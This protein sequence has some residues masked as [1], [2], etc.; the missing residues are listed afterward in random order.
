[1]KTA[2][3]IVQANWVVPIEPL[4]K[5][6]ERHALVIVDGRIAAIMPQDT[7]GQHYRSPVLRDLSDHVLLPGLVNAHTHAAMNLLRGY[8]NDTPLTI[9]LEDHIW[10]A[11]AK[12]VSEEFVRDGTEL[13]IAEMMLGGTTCFQDMYMFPYAAGQ[14]AHDTGMRAV[15]GLILIDFPT[16]WAV[17]ASDCLK[18]A[19]TVHDQLKPYLLLR[20]AF[21]PH[22]LYT[23]PDAS[24]QQMRILAEELEL[25][26]HIHLH[27]TAN[28]VK[29]SVAQ[30]RMRPIERLQQL[31]IFGPNLCAV[32][33][34]Q[35]LPAEIT[36]LSNHNVNV[37]HC[38]ESNMKLASGM[39]PVKSLLDA[40][41]NV[42][43]GTD[44]AASNNDLDMFGEMRT[45]A[46]LAKVVAAD[47]SAF[48]AAE[49]LYAATLGGARALGLEAEIGS[50]AIGKSA[51]FI[52]VN[53]AS[54]QT[55]PVF[56]PIPQLVF[57]A[58]RE[59]VSDVWING[60]EVVR[61]RVLQ[62]LN[63]DRLM[64][65]ANKWRNRLMA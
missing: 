42:A 5:V 8:A 15:I 3:L 27:E 36:Q 28:E 58:G 38:P 41:I 1:M 54:L 43:L 19:L 21:A 50:L 47:A 45:A 60:R 18:K 44:G 52:A 23:V 61:D 62:T 20:T 37:V 2:D 14:A 13:A 55:Q 40:H 6:L 53:L 22:S 10:P 26:I 4:G 34:T 30:H 49:V 9:W 31:N 63:P 46:L 29:D 33:M 11:E 35:L 17:D 25:P 32:H 24:M 16:P 57:S 64:A 59:H 65:T 51:D 48:S 12:W 39:C 7:V 56:D